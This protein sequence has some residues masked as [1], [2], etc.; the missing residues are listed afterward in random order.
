MKA[1]CDKSLSRWLPDNVNKSKKM[2][3]KK[4][5]DELNKSETLFKY[6][7][8]CT[9]ALFGSKNHFLVLSFFFFDI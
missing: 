4:H 6:H 3:G 2:K 1:C 5:K 8:Y 7:D 9:V